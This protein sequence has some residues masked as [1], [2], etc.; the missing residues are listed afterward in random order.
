MPIVTRVEQVAQIASNLGDKPM[1]NHTGEPDEVLPICRKYSF[2]D[3]PRTVSTNIGTVPN[4][5]SFLRTL[6][7]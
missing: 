3:I 2:V 1:N 7:V 6:V 5:W 4:P